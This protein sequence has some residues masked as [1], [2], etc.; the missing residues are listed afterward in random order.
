MIPFAI[1]AGTSL[2]YFGILFGVAFYADKCRRAGYS[3]TSNAYIYA[4]SLNVFLS[5]W[6]F[7]GAVGRAANNGID[8]LALYLGPSLIV[9]TWWLLLRKMVRASRE[10]HIV[11]FAD[12]ISSRYGKSASIGAVVTLFCIIGTLPYIAIQLRAITATFDM[13]S[14]PPVVSPQHLIDLFN[15]FDLLSV[16]AEQLGRVPTAIS[17]TLPSYIDSGLI[18]ALILGLFCVLFGARH[19]DASERHEGLIAAV[20]LESLVKLFAFLALGLFVTFGLF[21]GFGDLFEQFSR[22]SPRTGELISLPS[23][24]IPYSQW[25]SLM[26]IGMLA[27]FC[28]PGQFHLLVIENSQEKHIRTAMWLFPA[29]LLLFTLFVIPIAAAGLVFYGGTDLAA[30]YFVLRIP[31]EKGPPWLTMLIF[32]G[33]LSASAGMV[34][35]TSVAL[36]TMILN[37]LVVPAILKIR[38][39]AAS[40]SGL[41]INTKRVAIFAV[42]LGGYFYNEMISASY[43]LISIVLI[44]F[45][46]AIQFAPAL[47]GGLLWKRASRRGAL[48]GLVLGF[49]VWSYTLLLPSLIA[50][51]CFPCNILDQGPWGFS[52]LRP[53]AL[54]GLSGLD[55]WS[56]ALF[57]SLLF[58]LG[59]FVAISLFGQLTPSE[60]E[61]VD[62]FVHV[63]SPPAEPTGMKILSKAP[64]VREFV[65]LMTKFIGEER[66]QSAIGDYLKDRGFDHRGTLPDREVPALKR[67]TEKTLAGSVGTAPARIIIENYLSARGSKMEDVFDIFGNVTLSRNASREQLSVLYEAARMVASGKGLQTTLDDILRLL[68]QQFMLDLCII[69]I[70]DPAQNALVTKSQIGMTEGHLLTSRIQLHEQTFVTDTFRKNAVVVIND[71]ETVNNP[72]SAKVIRR[73]GIKSMAHAPIVIEDQPVGV[74]SAYSKTIKGIFTEEF[75]EFFTSL[76][77]Q[78][79]VAWRN[80]QQAE[81]LLEAKEHQK[82]MEIAKRIQLSLLPTTLP[83]IEGLSLAGVCEPASQVGGDYYD[84][85][86]NGDESLDILIADVSGHNVGAALM[87]AEARTFIHALFHTFSGP[88]GIMQALNNFFNRD[89]SEAELFITL[90]YLRLDPNSRRFSYASAGHNPPLLFRADIGKCQALDAEGLILG[91]KEE[92]DFEE[93]V[94]SLS[95]GDV[96]LLYTD[97]IIEARNDD[98]ELFG[99]PR[100]RIFLRKHHKLPPADIAVEL[101]STVRQFSGR[102]SFEDD[103]SLVIIKADL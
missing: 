59:P 48:T 2:L 89:L 6:T 14:I 65:E 98:E 46:A 20:A 95:P 37:N 52:F 21:D 85:L 54:F 84:V 70:Y 40:L 26:V 86:I 100:L 7:Y 87:M 38:S 83:Q 56:H 9:L 66:A 30:D 74:L 76:A 77:G 71:A 44:S 97:G 67:F 36:S 79:G 8:F 64:S 33:G 90:F 43:G 31:M 13:L 88:A 49:A 28:L 32:L 10:Q 19:L 75:M 42:I 73:E 101:L 17:P 58:N 47:I 34:M 103:V 12:F 91:I 41:L 96:L 99:E 39:G 63:L 29:Y 50:S 1:V 55:V 5:A 61:Q 82:E 24:T 78:V 27:I 68:E 18:L 92:V 72:F 15:T 80:A 45:V 22:H 3:I 4:L 60:K 102:E 62:R 16:P 53:Q 51:G 23:A 25:F 93:K 11:S 69:R 81:K 57:W 94:E 35:V